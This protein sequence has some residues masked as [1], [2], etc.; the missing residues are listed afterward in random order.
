M[1]LNSNH[2]DHLEIERYWQS[3]WDKNLTF[4]ANDFDTHKKGKCYILD[5]F[6]YPS[7]EG[8]H[9][10]HPE[11]YTA[12][13]IISRFKHAQGFNVLHPMGWDAFG[14]PA[15]NH[16]VKTGTH[17]AINTK[18]NIQVFKKQLKSLGL[19]IDWT[20]E[21]DT[22]DPHYYRWTQWIFLELYKKGLAYVD[23][24]PVWWCPAM[25]TI[26]ANEEVIDG[27]SERGNH[28][29]E[30]RYLRQWVLRITQYADKLL[31]GLD[32]L[33]W[34]DSTK[35]M[36]TAWIGKSTG[37]NLHFGIQDHPKKELTV[38]TTRADTLYGVTYVVIA[39]EHPL[40]DELTTAAHK[41][42]VA[43]YKKEASKKSDLDRTDLAKHK[44][45]IFT[46]SYAI[47]PLNQE[48][49][50][51]WVADYVLASYGTGAVMAVPAHD[52]RDFE[53]ASKFNLPIK[54]VITKEKD[55]NTIESPY[56]GKGYLVNSQEFNSLNSDDAIEKI[57]EKLSAQ[58]RGEATV[59]YK[60]RDWLFS[61][62]RYW[63]EPFP[64]IWVDKASF[65]LLQSIENS[66]V[67]KT[68]PDSPVTFTEKDGKTLYALPIPS[69]QL[70][71]LL[72]Q[73]ESYLPSDDGESPLAHASE[74]LNTWF[75]LE[76]GETSSSQPSGNHWVQGRRE[77]NTMPNWA[78]SCWYYLRYLD[79]QNDKNFLDSKI[80]NY[81]KGPDLYIGG[82]E[83]AVLHL[84]YARFWHKVLFELGYVAEDEPF[85]KV[86]H[87]GLI[88]GE[89]EYHVYLNPKGEMVSY[90]QVSHSKEELS[91]QA[92]KLEDLD[93]KGEK[94][95][96]KS[97]PDIQV[98][99]KSHKMSK[100]RGNVV[101]PDHIIKDYGADALRMYEMFLGPLEANKPWSTTNIEGVSR[102]LRRI[103]REFIEEDT[104]KVNA[105]ILKNHKDS[106][107]I[108]KLKASTIIGVT[109]DIENI[110]LNTAISKL[111][112]F[113]NA[114]QK[115]SAISLETCSEFLQLLA[116]FAPHIAEELWERIGHKPSI[117]KA[118]WPIANLNHLQ[119]SE[120]KYVIQI[121]GKTRG[122]V[123]V[124][125]GSIKEDVIAKAKEDEKINVFIAN[126]TILKDVF[127][128]GKILN[129]VIKE[130]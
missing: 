98:E 62:Q 52:E 18:K 83:H 37:L 111:M 51:I 24:Y 60:L 6:P 128:P 59:N 93:Q 92:L 109:E 130:N 57:T 106:E 112:I 89:P 27:R 119:S 47:N 69:S 65:D 91:A 3:F 103:W 4:Q 28:P 1:A 20:R 14:L 129:L 12:T 86:V 34:P 41:D 5:M 56:F 101:N 97:R 13:D 88:L 46:G 9:I 124:P 45:G 22:T 99:A 102:F 23:N 110:R 72:P 120:D 96:L 44:S 114:F 107:E 105:K 10:G 39:P 19:A 70:P 75:N 61:R 17:P 33:D 81:W 118:P 2:Y 68:L 108:L 127:V 95:F 71:V 63:G 116:P 90:E 104:G 8:L 125:K 58:K 85:R 31:D 25:K 36:Q 74:W 16:A 82:S 32:K 11:G 49:V 121:N 84:L 38:F 50:P 78:G 122:T 55:Q 94:Y 7:G 15:E 29:V 54:A 126:K 43:A 73:V 40:I 67:K 117:V 77:T 48:L 76:T 66:E 30:R 100:S 79:P 35:R 123:L 115:E 80:S 21:I 113:M 64:I 53:F 26:L 42:Q 87:Q